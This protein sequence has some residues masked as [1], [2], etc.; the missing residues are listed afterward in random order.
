MKLKKRCMVLCACAAALSML[1]ACAGSNVTENT[2]ELKKNGKI[3]EYAIE[4]FSA[5]YYDTEELQSYV[6]AQV[7]EWLAENDGS[8]KISKS[9]V[10]EQTAYL[11]VEYDSADTFSD[12]SG[13]ECFAGTIVQAQSGGYDFDVDF[14]KAADSEQDEDSS[15]SVDEGEGNTE[16]SAKEV[17]QD[18]DL[19]VFIVKGSA[20]IVVPGQIQYVSAEG[21][22]IVDEHTVSVERIQGAQDTGVLVYVLYK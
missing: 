19:K 10:E 15:V 12:F 9:E 1:T 5:S 16:V 4:D 17:L 3:I 2:V 6:E 7:D 8:I 20:N 14:I 11:T 22:K 18:D 13:E 21:T